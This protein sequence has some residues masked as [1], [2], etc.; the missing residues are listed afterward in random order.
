MPILTIRHLT[1]YHYKQPV[2]FGEHRMMLRPRD[3]DDQKVLESELEITPEPSQLAWTQDIFGNHV[4][5]ARFAGPSLAASLRKHHSGRPHAGGLRRS[6][7]RRFCANP[8]VCLRGGRRALSGALH[9]ASVPVTTA[10]SLGC[11]VPPGRRVGRHSRASCRHD[12]DHQAD[13]QAY[14]ATR[15][16]NTEIQ[17]RPCSCGAEV[18]ATLRCS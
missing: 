11:R 15:E 9:R 17:L 8:S 10:R 1:T 18:V 2:A 6:R 7:Y 4:A 13:L 16:G 3:D 5:I 12:A 14:G